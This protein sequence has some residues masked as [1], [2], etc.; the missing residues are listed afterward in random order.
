MMMEDNSE[1]MSGMESSYQQSATPNNSLLPYQ[2]QSSFLSCQ[3]L[4]SLTSTVLQ[5]QNNFSQANSQTIV[6]QTQI[7]AVSSVS[8]E[9]FNLKSDLTPSNTLFVTPAHESMNQPSTEMLI[10]SICDANP[11]N[12]TMIKSFSNESGMTY[13]WATK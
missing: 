9:A 3:I 13:E 11:Y 12:L 7:S 2:Q 8:P 10:D 4:T 6:M 1:E 5:S